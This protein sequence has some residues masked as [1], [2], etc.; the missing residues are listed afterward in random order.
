MDGTS[1]TLAGTRRLHNACLAVQIFGS[2]PINESASL[3]VGKCIS[4]FF[5]A[6]TR[7]KQKIEIPLQT[8][9]WKNGGLQLPEH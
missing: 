2:H 5:L 6:V 4:Y 1:Q 9:W 3:D 8:M 7:K